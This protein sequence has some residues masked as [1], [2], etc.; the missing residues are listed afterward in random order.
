MKNKNL[1]N[2]DRDNC[3]Y[4]N[5]HNCTSLPNVTYVKMTDGN[6]IGVTNND[7]SLAKEI[8]E[9]CDDYTKD[10]AIEEIQC[11][12]ALYRLRCE[13]L[14]VIDCLG[15]ILESISCGDVFDDGTEYD[16]YE[17]EQ[18]ERDIQII[19]DYIAEERKRYEE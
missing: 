1:D 2:T 11:R 4:T 19:K 13:S 9:I 14:A 16:K 7:S 12:V 5:K 3:I 10:S 17:R 15:V 8:V 6:T 18:R